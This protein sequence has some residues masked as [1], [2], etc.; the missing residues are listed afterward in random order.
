MDE[1]I[2]DIRDIVDTVNKRTLS[3][4]FMKFN[5]EFGEFSAEVIKL[6]GL[7]PKPY[8]R[9]HLVEE[10]ADTLQ[11]LLAIYAELEDKTDISIEEIIAKIPEKNQKWRDT[12]PKY[13]LKHS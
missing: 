8:D 1:I 2:K 3:E 11:C 13:T 10:A 4:M 12:I 6:G 9:E 5:E 7:S